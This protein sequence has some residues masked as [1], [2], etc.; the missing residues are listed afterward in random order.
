[1]KIGIAGC[2]GIGSNVAYHLVR[3]GVKEFKIGD[4]DVVEEINL[5]RQFYFQNQIGKEKVFC[6]QENLLAI[7]KDI[8]IEAEN[9]CF[10]RH[11]LLPFFEDCDLI[12]E[13][14]DDKETKVLLLE[15]FLPTDKIIVAASGIAD[16]D[17][18][19]LE[20]RQLANNLYVVGDFEKEMGKYK[21]YSHKVNMVSA[22]MA[23]LILELGGYLEK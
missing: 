2:G 7:Q 8:Q 6:L 14:F 1:M 4:F 5:N 9:I 19:N 13:A 21:T 11:N 16:S 18:D 10:D 15:T 23:K 3:T 12:V 17:I 20:I 22:I